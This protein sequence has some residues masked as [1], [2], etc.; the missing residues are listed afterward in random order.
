ML[1]ACPDCSKGTWGWAQ[2]PYDSELSPTAA[3]PRG[4]VG[5]KARADTPHTAEACGHDP[6]GKDSPSRGKS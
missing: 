3:A 2:P 6:K 4:S 1:L 5:W